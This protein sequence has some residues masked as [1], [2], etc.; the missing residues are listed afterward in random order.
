MSFILQVRGTATC[1]P[2]GRAFRSVAVLPAAGFCRP[3]GTS[4]IGRPNPA[5]SLSP[6]VGMNRGRNKTIRV[7]PSQPC[8]QDPRGETRKAHSMPR[9]GW[10]ETKNPGACDAGAWKF[11]QARRVRPRRPRAPLSARHR[12]KAASPCLRWSRHSP[13]PAPRLRGLAGRTSCREARSP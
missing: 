1:R 10:P 6:K 3:A 8:D 2:K 11:H 5:F 12:C 7:D 13:P 4:P 9:A